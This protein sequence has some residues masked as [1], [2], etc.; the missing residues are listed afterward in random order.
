MKSILKVLSLS[1]IVSIA[2]AGTQ[3]QCTDKNGTFRQHG[4]NHPAKANFSLGLNLK[5]DQF[6]ATVVGQIA[7]DY[8]FDVNEKE[9]LEFADF[10][11]EGSFDSVTVKQN[12]KYKPSK[13]KNHM[14]FRDV[15]A[16]E[17]STGMW[18]VLVMPAM[19]GYQFEAHYIFQ[20]GDHIG[21]TLDL[22]CITTNGKK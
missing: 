5:D 12:L 21:G 7:A 15:N 3:Y 6:E 10:H 4:D 19:P 16:T 8:D 2:S 20:A 22:N 9:N 1:L 11:Y 17:S 14:Q 18:G 13:Y